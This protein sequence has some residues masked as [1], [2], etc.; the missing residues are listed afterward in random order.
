V[1]LPGGLTAAPVII[2]GL[3]SAGREDCP[4]DFEQGGPAE[5]ALR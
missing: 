1:L 5:V 3:P 4:D 2:V